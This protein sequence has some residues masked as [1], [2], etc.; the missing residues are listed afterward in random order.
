V[1][2][3]DRSTSAGARISPVFGCLLFLFSICF[4]S[5]APNILTV[6]GHPTQARPHLDFQE[7]ATMP[8]ATKLPYK[9]VGP[10]KL[11]RRWFPAPPSPAS[12]H[13][14]NEGHA[15]GASNIGH[16]AIF[17]SATDFASLALELVSPP[18]NGL[19]RSLCPS[20]GPSSF[21]LS[22]FLPRRALLYGVSGRCVCRPCKPLV[23]LEVPRLGERAARL[24]LPL[25]GGQA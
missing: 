7:A 20:P 14:S 9:A 19:C 6:P 25:P 5:F 22:R 4:F 13:F 10:M 16:S 8:L 1:R 24:Y 3:A 12:R 17:A 15:M 23:L 2:C 11:V 21:A 18:G